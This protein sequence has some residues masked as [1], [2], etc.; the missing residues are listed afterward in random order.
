MFGGYNRND[1]TL[2]LIERLH[3]RSKRMELLELRMPEPLRRFA[4]IKISTTKILLLGGLLR[5]SKESDAVF[6]FD[7]EKD[8]YT[9]EQL[10]K[11]DK[12]G[13]IDLPIILD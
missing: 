3:I 12:A 2:T 13:I 9:I 5:M 8:Q 10:D 11:I 7:L 1:G 6:C 4:S